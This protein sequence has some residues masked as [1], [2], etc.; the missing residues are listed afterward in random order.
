MVRIDDGTGTGFGAKV[1]S[2]NRLSTRS[3][4][5]SEPQQQTKEGNSYNINTAVINLSSG[6]ESALLFIKN[7]E[8]FDLVLEKLFVSLGKSTAGLSTENV[9]V[10]IVRNPSTGTLISGGVDIE[11]VNRNFGSSNELTAETKK[12]A[13]AST[14]T[15][16]A[17]IAD[18]LAQD[19]NEVIVDIDLSIPKGSSIGV[20]I[21]P[22]AANTSMDI[23]LNARV[24]LDT[25][26][27]E[28]G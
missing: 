22:K 16:G 2:K 4:T 8:D 1:D 15:D 17:D 21:T 9:K 27:E 14:L 12:G 7:N 5:V 18:I 11:K 6:S 13:E 10:T 20:K 23:V 28:T 25:F 26:F 24:T 19:G 3:I